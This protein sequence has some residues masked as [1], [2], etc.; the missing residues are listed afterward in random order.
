MQVNSETCL[1]AVH[2]LSHRL[3]GNKF[4]DKVE[5]QRACTKFRHYHVVQLYWV[6]LVKTTS[7]FNKLGGVYS[8]DDRVNQF[9][10]C[11]SSVNNTL[12]C[13]D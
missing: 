10:Q 4:T 2:L 3:C 7:C 9:G 5:Y 11:G 13:S 1:L 12:R 6:N 8:I